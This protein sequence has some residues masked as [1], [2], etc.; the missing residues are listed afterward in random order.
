MKNV[1]LNEELKVQFQDD[2]EWREV[3]VEERD[4][5][6]WEEKGQTYT[7][8]YEKIEKDPNFQSPVCYATELLKTDGGY[9][10]ARKIKFLC[11]FDLFY[12]LRSLKPNQILKI[13][14][15][16]DEVTEL[17]YEKK[18]FRVLTPTKPVKIVEPF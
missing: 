5:I 2:E 17:G 16:H 7:L 18:I 8:I 13:A 15:E 3:K 9:I 11:P 10:P 14:Y 12:K 1:K 6:K 4:W